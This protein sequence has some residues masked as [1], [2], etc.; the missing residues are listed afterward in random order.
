[1]KVKD[2]GFYFTLAFFY[3]EINTFRKLRNPV[4]RLVGCWAVSL[5]KLTHL[6]SIVRVPETLNWFDRCNF[7]VEIG[8]GAP[9]T[10]CHGLGVSPLYFLTLL[11]YWTFIFIYLFKKKKKKLFIY[12]F[13][14]SRQSS[15][16]QELVTQVLHQGAVFNNWIKQIPV[17]NLN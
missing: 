4:Q 11:P 2:L 9:L 5:P 8:T 17:W 12:F 1:M 15:S 16:H 13:H 14:F 3:E 7:S 10:M 6:L